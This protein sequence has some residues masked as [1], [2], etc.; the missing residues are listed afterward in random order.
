MSDQLHKLAPGIYA[1][2]GEL[3]LDLPEL[4]KANGYADTPANRA[5]LI[6]AARELVAG[7]AMTLEETDAPIERPR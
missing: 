7:T 3:H 4:L 1:K 6:A 2:G 5:M